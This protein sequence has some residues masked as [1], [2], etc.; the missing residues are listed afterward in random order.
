VTERPESQAGSR[1]RTLLLAVGVVLSALWPEIRKGWERR[2]F[3]LA[4]VGLAVSYS[5]RSC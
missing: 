3:T 4:G 2:H 5:S 1:R